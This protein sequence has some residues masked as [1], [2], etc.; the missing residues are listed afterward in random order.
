M[1]E[2]LYNT[3]YDELL[4]WCVALTK[5]KAQAEDLVQ[6]AFLRAIRH[7]TLLEQMAFRKRRAWMFRTVRNLYVDELRKAAAAVRKEGLLFGLPVC[8]G[9]YS[10]G[11]CA[12]MLKALSEEERVLFVMRYLQGY[13]SV[14]IGKLFGL[15]PATVRSK[16]VSAR[17]RLR[18]EWE[19]T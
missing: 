1:I 8:S 7:R 17:K 9:D 18:K 4:C 14:E 19:N 6:E 3:C 16:L 12:Q 13:N 11:E 15:P 5:Q 2:E 10:D